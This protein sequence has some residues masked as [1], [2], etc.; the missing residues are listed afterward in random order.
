M[1]DFRKLAVWRKAHALTLNV[2][3]AIAKIRRAEH[4]S[5]RNQILRAADSIPTNIVEGTGQESGKEFGRFL[6]IAVKSASELE[7]HLT[8]AR[9]LRLISNSDFE[10]LSAQ[11]IEVRKMLYG[12]RNRVTTT[13]RLTHGNVPAS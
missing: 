4:G 10:S 1:S 11:A 12:L 2:H 6:S 5:M 9:D 7:Y 8:L 3:R 13:P